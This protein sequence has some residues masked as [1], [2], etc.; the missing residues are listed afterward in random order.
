M[1]QDIRKTGK[2]AELKMKFAG[3][4][5][6]KNGIGV[7]GIATRTPTTVT[8]VICTVKVENS[9]VQKI[10]AINWKNVSKKNT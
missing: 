10:Q 6:V 7:A 2:V 1:R 3:N 8:K 4:Q 5:N 9:R